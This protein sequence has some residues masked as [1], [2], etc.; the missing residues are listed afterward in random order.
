MGE[1]LGERGGYGSGLGQCRSSPTNGHKAEMHSK[2]IR[3]V[4]TYGIHVNAVLFVSG[5]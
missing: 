4:N 1:V 2:A 5:Y 3:K